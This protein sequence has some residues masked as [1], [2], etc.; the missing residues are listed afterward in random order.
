VRRPRR[1]GLK[2]AS[3]RAEYLV[4][5]PESLL[6]E[7]AALLE[8]RSSQGLVVKAVAI[9]DVW[10][11]FGHGE[12]R[13]EAVREFL[14]YA[15]HH[16]SAPS[17]RY[18]V[19]LGDATYDF[20]DYHRT[21]QVNQV[22]PL[23]VKTS[24]LWTAS[25]PLYAAV[26]GED[27]L[28]DL[29]IGRLSARTVEEARILVGKVLAFEE[30]GGT[31]EGRAVLVADNADAAGEFEANSDAVGAMLGDREIEKL[32]LRDVGAAGMRPAIKDAFNRGSSLMSYV[33]H[34]SVA[35]WATEN[36]FNIVDA[37]TLAPQSQQPFLMTMNCLNGYIQMPGVNSLGE[38]LVKAEGKGAIAAFAPSGLSQDA[39]AHL[40]QRA[41]ITELTSGRHQRLG[42]AILAAQVAYADTGAF[43][44]LLSIYHLLGDPALE[45]R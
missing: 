33:G 32:Y 16:W 26:N 40:Y 11:E 20:K 34:G 19:L 2:L 23:M 9:E 3:N 14:A 15:Y 17:L 12:S 35:I 38:E 4:L 28:P 7:A 27:S 42:D 10:E 6:G 44:E 43:P 36:F 29:A 18:V 5:G 21:G 22:P 45:L 30:G 37:R 41:L 39:P 25:D 8:R 31:L 13:P 24:Y 1:A